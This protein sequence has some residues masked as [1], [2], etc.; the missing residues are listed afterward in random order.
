MS[1]DRISGVAGL[2]LDFRRPGRDEAWCPTVSG[3]SKRDLLKDV[4]SIFGES[5]LYV[6]LPY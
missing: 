1:N 6:S 5:I 3:L 2:M 4:L